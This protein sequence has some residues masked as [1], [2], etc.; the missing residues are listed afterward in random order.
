MERAGIDLA[1]RPRRQLAHGRVP[2]DLRRER[3][4]DM[5]P[6]ERVRSSARRLQRV[7]EALA[8]RVELRERERAQ[9][10]GRASLSYDSTIQLDVYYT[11]NWRLADD[12]AIGANTVRAVVSAKGAY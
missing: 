3:R 7:E 1:S 8:A 9:V 4:P 5:E 11:D 12:L 10:N 2:L 6:P